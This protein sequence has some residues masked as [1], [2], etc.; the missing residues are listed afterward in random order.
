MGLYT[1]S[2]AGLV[3]IGAA[4]AFISQN[5]GTE[6]AATALLF[7]LFGAIICGQLIN[8]YFLMIAVFGFCVL[9]AG[10]WD[11]NLAHLV[12]VLYGLRV[13][14]VLFEHYGVL[15]L[16]W[17]QEINSWFVIVQ[18]S[19]VIWGASQNGGIRAISSG[20]GNDGRVH[21]IFHLFVSV[22]KKVLAKSPKRDNGNL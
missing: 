10:R 14:L 4:M 18:A 20:I 6:N 3:L 22:P 15:S 13:L 12:N 8:D 9:I 2:V 21:R 11:S 5:K 17:Y 16:F 19:I 1:L 7:S